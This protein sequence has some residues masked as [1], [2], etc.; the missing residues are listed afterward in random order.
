[1]ALVALLVAAGI[2]ANGLPPPAQICAKTQQLGQRAVASDPESTI[3]G[4]YVLYYSVDKHHMVMPFGVYFETSGSGEYFV[5]EQHTKLQRVAGSLSLLR[6]YTKKEN[7]TQASFGFKPSA[8][9]AEL[10]TCPEH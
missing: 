3:V 5:A 6:T 10:F 7:D 9:R 4:R 8:I 2:L 1:M